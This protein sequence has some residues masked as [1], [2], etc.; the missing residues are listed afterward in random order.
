MTIGGVA[1]APGANYSDLPLIAPTGSVLNGMTGSGGMGLGYDAEDRINGGSASTARTSGLKA[2][3][4]E[5]KA[6]PGA[7]T[8][9]LRS[10]IA[11]QIRLELAGAMEQKGELT[12]RYNRNETLFENRVA[13][14]TGNQ[15]WKGAPFFHIPFMAPRLM[16]RKASLVGTV[17][18]HDPM[19]RFKRIGTAQREQQ[20]EQ[21]VQFFLNIVRFKDRLDEAA[22]MAMLTNMAIW[23]VSF[24]EHPAGYENATHTGPFAG[25]VFD[26]IHPR[27]FFCYPANSGG[28]F[29][30]RLCGHR[31]EVRRAWITE[32]QARGEYFQG[33]AVAGINDLPLRKQEGDLQNQNSAPVE[34]ADDNI[35]LYDLLWRN[36]LNGDGLEE[37]YRVIWNNTSQS[38][39]LLEKYECPYPWYVSMSIKKEYNVFWSEGSPAQDLQGLQLLMNTLVNEFIWGTMM[40]SRPPVLTESWSATDGSVTNYAPGE[41]RNVRRI[42]NTLPIPVSFDPQGFPEIIQLIQSFGDLASKSPDTMSGAPSVER[43]STATEQNIKFAGFQ[44]SSGDDV[45]AISQS[46]C[47]LAMLILWLLGTYYDRWSSV[48]GD[49]VSVTDPTL[50]QQPFQVDLSSRDPDDSPQLQLQ[51]NQ[52]LL[53]LAASFPQS[54]LPIAELLIGIVQSTN[55]PNKEDLVRAIQSQQA[56]MGQ[57]QDAAQLMALLHG[58]MP[59]QPGAQQGQP[60]QQPAKP[61]QGSGANTRPGPG[62]GQAANATSPGPMQGVPGPGGTGGLNGN[63]NGLAAILAVAGMGGGFGN[64]AAAA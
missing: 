12:E 49:A 3:S 35:V 1:L 9:S 45:S 13:G 15:P 62:P 47:H 10:T 25:I 43:D 56:M 42:G 17:T 14:N 38:I 61:N 20:I 2:I 37:L 46:L 59:G 51:Q 23:R 39:L 33:S 22:Q 54:G 63:R 34:R 21:T 7:D 4:A 19:Y 32:K 8:P 18:Q 53:Q 31:F 44:L 16:T 57:L 55:L 58:A 50:F 24:E 29:R 30:A 52:L 36:D 5:S 26:V 27:E 28:I 40:R 11:G 64:T 6:P 60:G 41:Y 48:Y